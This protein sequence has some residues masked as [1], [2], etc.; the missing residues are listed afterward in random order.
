MW[1]KRRPLVLV[2][3]DELF[4]STIFLVFQNL[5]LS[6]GPLSVDYQIRMYC[7]YPPFVVLLVTAGITLTLG[8]CFIKFEGFKL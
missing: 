1:I 2:V 5:Q 7:L 3:I 4:R 6:F 8:K